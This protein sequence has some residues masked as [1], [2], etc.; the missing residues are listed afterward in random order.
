MSSVTCS[1]TAADILSMSTQ[2]VYKPSVTLPLRARKLGVKNMPATYYEDDEEV[3]TKAELTREEKIQRQKIDCIKNIAQRAERNKSYSA[4]NAFDD[5]VL[6]SSFEKDV[7][8]EMQNSINTHKTLQIKQRT[9]EKI[10]AEHPEFFEQMDWEYNPDYDDQPCEKAAAPEKKK[11]LSDEKVAEVKKELVTVQ[12]RLAKLKE[13]Y[14]NLNF[15]G[16]NIETFGLRRGL[17]VYCM[18]N[19]SLL[20]EEIIMLNN[21]EMLLMDRLTCNQNTEGLGFGT[22]SNVYGKKTHD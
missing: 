5:D 22:F 8:A 3:E 10:A 6:E 15:G 18:A 14:L 20:V 21:Y 9:I 12:A 17:S 16:E 4:G 1:P 2:P 7:L 13:E 11:F 19:E